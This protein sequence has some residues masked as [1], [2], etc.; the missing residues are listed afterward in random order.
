LKL[1]LRPAA[2]RRQKKLRQSS[3]IRDGF[4]VTNNTTK[5]SQQF[6]EFTLIEL[7]GCGEFT[8]L[9]TFTWKKGFGSLAFALGTA[10]A[11]AALPRLPGTTVHLLVLHP[12]RRLAT[13]L[14]VKCRRFEVPAAFAADR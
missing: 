6:Y 12:V 7:T 8:F 1:C 10:D 13:R 3:A 11:D 14:P 2:L 9:F 4:I 5:F